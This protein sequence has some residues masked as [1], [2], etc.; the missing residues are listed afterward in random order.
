MARTI[1][2]ASQGQDNRGGCGMK[3][4]GKTCYAYFRGCDGQGTCDT[5]CQWYREG[6]DCCMWREYDAG[7]D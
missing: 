5:D 6:K 2:A 3:V 1:L 7:R 4:N